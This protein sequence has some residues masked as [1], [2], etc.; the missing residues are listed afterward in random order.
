MIPDY[1]Q[2]K[3]IEL[4]DI[5]E[6]ASATSEMNAEESELS[7]ANFYIWQDL[8]APFLTRIDAVICILIRC[9]NE[10]HFLQPLKTIAPSST[11]AIC[12][13]HCGRLSRLSR[14]T[15]EQ[16]NVQ[17]DQ[18]SSLTDQ[19]DYLY[20]RR[21]LAELRGSRYDGKRNHI[22]RFKTQHPDWIYQS[23]DASAAGSALNL[24]DIWSSGKKD[25]V[26][27]H[28]LAE[29]SQRMALQRA[30]SAFEPLGLS[31]GAVLS[32]GRMLGFIL[33]SQL[34]HRTMLVHFQYGH[35]DAPGVMPLL[36]QEAAGS[37]FASYDYLNLE[38]D[39]GIAGLRKSKQS[40]HPLR[41]IP[42]FQIDDKSLCRHD[43]QVYGTEPAP[44][45]LGIGDSYPSFS[46]LISYFFKCLFA[47][48]SV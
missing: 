22:K 7:P 27:F 6:I 41:L 38:Q 33:G 42:K 4:S 20:L 1:P 15:V 16:M 3:F 43:A 34:N 5:D 18:I 13:R 32:N 39:I 37:T 47:S 9:G 28:H 30:F 17:H 14:R 10:V 29:S 23:L 11:L 19:Y 24:F 2:F 25:S 21:D 48:R 45:A 40:L 46:C 26:Y 12:L 36:L 8:E 31:G 35:P 44:P